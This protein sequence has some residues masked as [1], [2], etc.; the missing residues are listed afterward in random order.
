MEF[1]VVKSMYAID[2][3]ERTF[4]VK[5]AGVIDGRVQAQCDAFPIIEELRKDKD[6]RGK[7]K[8]NGSVFCL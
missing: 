1:D 8:N 3:D 6:S 2:L 5:D 4:Q 7:R